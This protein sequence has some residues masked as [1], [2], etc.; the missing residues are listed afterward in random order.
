M[1]NLALISI[2][3]DDASFRRA[4][5]SFVQS[6][7]YDVA[8]FETA[9]E[10][11]RSEQLDVTICLICDLHMPGMSGIELQNELRSQRYTLPIIFITAYGESKMRGQA[12]AAGALGFFDKPFHE[13]ELI[14]CLERVSPSPR[15]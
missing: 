15:A 10:F 8:V 9:E 2:V 3:D 12:L 13:Q 7:G 5:A 6:L 11:L 14:S 1:T 4:T